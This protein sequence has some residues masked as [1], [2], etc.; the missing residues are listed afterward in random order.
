[1]PTVI[2]RM[3]VALVHEGYDIIRLKELNDKETLELFNAV[4]DNKLGPNCKLCKECRKPYI[5]KKKS[6]SCLQT[7]C[8]H[9]CGCKKRRRR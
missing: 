9:P 2:K 1:M 6:W 4:T 3:R 8:I 5:Q 7:S